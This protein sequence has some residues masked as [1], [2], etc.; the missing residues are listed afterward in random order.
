MK[1][2]RH[3]RRFVGFTLIELLVVIAIIGILSALLLPVVNT[4]KLRAKRT[5]CVNHLRQIGL[6]FQM[7]AHE[8]DSKLP[9]QVPARDGGTMELVNLTNQQSADF[10]SAYRHFQT[11]SNEL[12]TPK[13]LVCA[14]D[15]RVA[16]ENFP[17][18]KN[19]NVSYFV[20]VRAE[21]GK[22]ASI[23]AGD[24]N[25]TSN[26]ADQS[27]LRLDANNYLRWTAELHR[28]KGNLLYGDGHVEELNRP[29]L[30]VTTGNPDTVASLILPKDEPPSTGPAPRP[31]IPESPSVPRPQRTVA[32][33]QSTGAP[34]F[35]A[36]TAPQS[37][38]IT[39]GSQFTA[40]SPYV[41]PTVESGLS[42]QTRTQQT[43]PTTNF[44]AVVAPPIVDD[45]E[46]LAM[47]SFDYQ[48]MKFLQAAIKWWY[49]LLLLVVLLFI[50]YTIW[51]EWRN[52]QERREGRQFLKD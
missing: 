11:L 49:L 32:G 22:T 51:R 33:N 21:Q 3:C 28:F 12:V 24:R 38:P 30:M 31:T 19:T 13:V 45:K 17:A 2:L 15:S 8:H 9:M 6:G 23:L 43:M 34:P 1:P 20:N 47:G 36:A 7:F 40:K 42:W 26:G 16:A 35:Q 52:R 14:M 10:T 29:A 37:P 41:L 18:L 50:A 39:T 25:L 48:L 27:V 44:I 5:T 46:E 4:T